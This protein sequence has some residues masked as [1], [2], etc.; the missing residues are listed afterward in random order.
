[1]PDWFWT[2]PRQ[3]PQRYRVAAVHGTPRHEPGGGVEGLVYRARLDDPTSPDH[4]RVVALKLLLTCPPARLPELQERLA[5]MGDFDDRHLMVVRDT[6]VGTALTDD[7]A[8]LSEDFDV[9]YVVSDWI[10]GRTLSEAAAEAGSLYA[11]DATA[12]VALAVDR[13]HRATSERA[14]LGVVHRDLKT[15]NVRVDTEDSV[16]LIDYG[17]ARPD[18]TDASVVGTPGWLAPEVAAGHAGGKPADVYGVGAIAHDLIVGAPPRLDGSAAAAERI[19]TALRLHQVPL[20]EDLGHHIAALLAT[21][22]ARRPDDMA[23]WADQLVALRNGRPLKRSSQM[24]WMVAGAA[25]VAAALTVAAIMWPRDASDDSSTDT[26]TAEA[27]AAQPLGAA[28]IT[29]SPSSTAP[30]TTWMCARPVVPDSPAGTAL[31]T[32]FD[33]ID[34][35]CAGPTEQL[36]EAVIVPLR[37]TKEAPDS[38]L[39][40]SPAT[41][42]VRLT[43]AQYNSYREIA[44]RSQPTNAALYGGYP[45]EVTQDD[46]AEAAII[47]LS[48]GGLIIGR[49]ADT[50]SFWIPQQAR[51]LWEANGGLT[52][53]LGAPTSNVFFAG[54]R[55]MLEFEG[56]YMEAVVQG[57]NPSVQTWLPIDASATDVVF[58]DDPAAELAKFGDTTERVLRQAGSTAWWV[59]ADQV[60]H[61]I[62]DGTTWGCLDAANRQVEG[63]VPG[64]AIASLELGPP[65]TCPGS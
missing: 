65:A 48:T 57:S 53:K 22:P 49:R 63:N 20:A 18:A 41:P 39:I 2:G 29:T 34:A 38:V 47:E 55:L 4:D 13:L 45:T 33:A 11:L 36:A 28:V 23:S 61:W 32:A 19:A 31:I 40:A 59:D 21:D 24:R 27:P 60:R 50:Q 26:A 9:C 15:S 25:A 52:G 6:F 56:G 3:H 5:T 62:S 58:I 12:E 16:V 37:T 44:G 10:E 64:Y 46:S 51:G 35:A 1:M 43:M 17:L 14:P 54:S 30:P 8:P 42:A 7:P